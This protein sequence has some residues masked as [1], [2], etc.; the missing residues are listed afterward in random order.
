MED[1]PDPLLIQP[2]PGPLSGV[3]ALPGSKSLTNRA[4]LLAALSSS[5]VRLE[6]ALF[7]RDSR[8]MVEGLRHLGFGVEVDEAT[9][10]IEVKG[11][12]GRIPQAEADIFVGN[13]GTAARF[14]TAL[15]ALHPEGRYRLD[16][17]EEM[18]KRPVKGLT[19]AL[20]AHGTRFHFEGEEGHFPFRMETAG[21]GGGAWD[22]DAGAS[23]QILSALLMIA[24]LVEGGMRLSAPGVRP[25]YVRMTGE[26]MKIFGARLEANE[27]W[28]KV[29]V[30]ADSLRGPDGGVYEVEPDASA[31]SYFLALPPMVGGD[32]VLRGLGAARLQGDLKFAHLLEEDFGL[33]IDR[34]GR[35]WRVRSS[36][37]PVG[38]VCYDMRT[39]S[40]PF[41]TLAVLATQRKGKVRIEGIGHTRFQETDRIHAMETELRRCGYA[42]RSGGDWIEVAGKEG[43]IGWSSPVEVETYE[44]HRVAMSFGLLGLCNR[45]AGKPW[46]AVK[47]PA[48]CGKTFPSYFEV[49]QSL[50]SKSAAK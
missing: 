46:L 28:E 36:S 43:T 17:D 21:L 11:E 34:E 37:I 30:E 25:A 20:A 35:D 8:L 40:D 22:V 6:G 14:L 31:A 39:F 4:L 42:V 50:Y 49:L 13:A 12:G 23:S 24:P 44:D 45:L 10:R 2:A 9:R 1:L 27:S 33:R 32:L 19:D 48:C 16:G 29:Q 15:L 7:S 18:R 41:L 26:L 47:N 3:V 38:P 5:R